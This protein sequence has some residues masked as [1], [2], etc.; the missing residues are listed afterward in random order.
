MKNAD[1]TIFKNNSD[2]FKCLFVQTPAMKDTMR[3]FPEFLA[4][5]ATYKLLKIGIPLFMIAAEDGNCQSEIASI[6]LL[7]NEDKKF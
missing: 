7:V 5:D 2:N 4:I 6:C 1:V 3:A